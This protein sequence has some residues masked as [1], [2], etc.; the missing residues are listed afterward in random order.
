[1]WKSSSVFGQRIVF[2]VINEDVVV[3]FPHAHAD[4]FQLPLVF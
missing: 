1:M 2:P 3:D 4:L